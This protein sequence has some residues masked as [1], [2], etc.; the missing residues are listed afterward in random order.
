MSDQPAPIQLPT[1]KAKNE[2]TDTAPS[3]PPTNDDFGPERARARLRMRTHG[4]AEEAVAEG[5]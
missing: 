1:V 2:R 3:T 4:G 5:F